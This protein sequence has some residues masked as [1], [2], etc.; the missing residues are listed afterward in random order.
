MTIVVQGDTIDKFSHVRL[1]QVQNT[2]G[3][4]DVIR[5]TLS[6]LHATPTIYLRDKL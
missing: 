5:S 1:S 3:Q 4:R 2:M 6:A